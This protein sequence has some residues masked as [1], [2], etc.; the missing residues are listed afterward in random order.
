M[1]EL[2]VVTYRKPGAKEKDNI[3]L[4]F[5]F[6]SE[7]EAMRW[8]KSEADEPGEYQAHG[9]TP[10]TGMTQEEA[11]AFVESMLSIKQ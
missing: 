10:P 4:P 8:A 2:W 3:V 7:E 9:F 1:N 11:K 5:V 6:D